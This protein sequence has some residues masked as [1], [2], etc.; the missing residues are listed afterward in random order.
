VEDAAA[1]AVGQCAVEQFAVEQLIEAVQSAG[2]SRIE[3]ERLFDAA[4]W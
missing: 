3:V 2:G 1:T 4:P